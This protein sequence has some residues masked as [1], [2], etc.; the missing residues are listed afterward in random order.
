M[1]FKK[2]NKP[3]WQDVLDSQKKM[4]LTDID[5]FCAMV[6]E[7]GYNCFEWNGRIYE[8]T[9]TGCADTGWLASEL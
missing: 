8:V 9:E 5:G 3:T 6:K 2:G 7:F 1:Y 4:H